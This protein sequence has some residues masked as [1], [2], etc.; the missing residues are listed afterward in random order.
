MF[1]TIITNVFFPTLVA[2]TT[3]ILFTHY[4]GKVGN[5][6]QINAETYQNLLDENVNLKQQQAANSERIHQ[7][8]AE[9]KSYKLLTASQQQII[10]DMQTRLAVVEK[11][12]RLLYI[13]S[14][15]VLA[16]YANAPDQP[17]LNFENEKRAILNSGLDVMILEGQRAT[18]N[19][20][21]RELGRGQFNI[22]EIG[23][24][25]TIDGEVMLEDGSLIRSAWWGRLA[26]RSKVSLFVLMACDSDSI[27]DALIRENVKAVIRVSGEILDVNVPKFTS[28][29]YEQI[30]SGLSLRDSFE[31]AKLALSLEDGEHIRFYGRWD[32]LESDRLDQND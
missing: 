31:N 13:D 24:H 1:E 29:L 17:V 12:T 6:V 7:L 4:R 19:N 5:V 20:I 10:T 28:I 14:F 21:I 26:R 8:E 18:R 32:A 30:S 2:M 3:M 22:V 27:A 15:S 16:I 23:M 11:K 25:A 9:L